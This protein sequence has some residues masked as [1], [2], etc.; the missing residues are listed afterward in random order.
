MSGGDELLVDGDLAGGDDQRQLPAGPQSPGAGG[1]KLHRFGAG[2]RPGRDQQRR[3][4]PSVVEGR[5]GVP[6]AGGAGRAGQRR[7][8]G[9]VVHQAV[10]VGEP[11]D[12][13]LR[14]RQH[15]VGADTCHTVSG[16]G[17]VPGTISPIGS[18]ALLW[19]GSLMGRV[20]P[21]QVGVLTPPRR[22]LTGA[23][24]CAAP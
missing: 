2:S 1:Q 11:G 5:G 21:G 4:L 8:G 22:V 13:P 20:C 15:R 7:P 19:A 18:G 24:N 12:Q 17:G 10:P 6:A 16:T 9:Q 23:S 14:H 3:G